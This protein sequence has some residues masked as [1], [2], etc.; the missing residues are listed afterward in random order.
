[1]TINKW[2]K[3]RNEPNERL[4]ILSRILAVRMQYQCFVDTC[5][6]TKFNLE[7]HQWQTLA[8]CNTKHPHNV[9]VESNFAQKRRFD[10][11]NVDVVML[12]SALT[13]YCQWAHLKW[14]LEWLDVFHFSLKT[15]ED[16]AIFE[17]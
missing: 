7:I 15:F 4:E 3:R 11:K 6:V 17:D 5:F 2:H 8:L 9:R 10:V 1:M 16:Q 13:T 12:V 14:Y